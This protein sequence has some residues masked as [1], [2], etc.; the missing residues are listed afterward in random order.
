MGLENKHKYS[1]KYKSER[2]LFWGR[3]LPWTQQTVLNIKLES[4]MLRFHINK[5]ELTTDLTFKKFRKQPH[6][7]NRLVLIDIM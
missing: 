3:F 6:F 1:A 4:L 7:S 2:L 5:L